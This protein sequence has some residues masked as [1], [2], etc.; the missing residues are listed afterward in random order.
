MRASRQEGGAGWSVAQAAGRPLTEEVEGRTRAERTP[1]MPDMVMTLDVSKLSGWLKASA[2]CRVE[3]KRRAKKGRHAGGA[4]RRD[5]VWGRR[6]NSVQGGCQLRRLAG[7][8][9]RRR[10]T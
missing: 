1:N 10:G 8:R 4:G 6:H 3:G 9:G 2:L 5:G 7:Q